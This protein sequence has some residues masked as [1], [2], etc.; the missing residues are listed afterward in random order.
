MTVELTRGDRDM[1]P[2]KVLIRTETNEQWY[3][4]NFVRVNE[5]QHL[6]FHTTDGKKYTIRDWISFIVEE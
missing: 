6:V 4:C 2:Y 3:D 5:Y 1:K